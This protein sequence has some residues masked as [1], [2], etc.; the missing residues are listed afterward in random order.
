MELSRFVD[1]ER[2]GFS[3]L[4]TAVRLFHAIE[5]LGRTEAERDAA[6]A[7]IAR[8]KDI[9][10]KVTK[11]YQRLG[12][13]LA[14][15]EAERDRALEEVQT[16]RVRYAPRCG[17]TIKSDGLGK[18]YGCGKLCGHDGPCET[19]EERRAVLAHSVPGSDKEK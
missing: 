3:H 19:A 10:M 6:H 2:D 4:E 8:R 12:K 7:N 15:T 5:E 16:L 18:V 14:E 17:K 1:A 13:R 9:A 11:M